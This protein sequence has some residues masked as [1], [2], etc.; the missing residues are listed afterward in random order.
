MTKT[1]EEGEFHIEH[2]SSMEASSVMG[3]EYLGGLIL[4]TILLKLGPRHAAV[5]ACVS[6]RLRAAASED[7][8]WRDFCAADFDLSCPEAPQ[9]T[10]CASFKVAYEQWLTSFL[11]YPLPLVR[12]A[13]Q[14][15]GGIR[16][17]MS[18]NFPEANDTLRRGAT[19][20]EIKR[21]E[22]KLGVKFPI[23]TRIL[24]RFCDGQDTVAFD[25][26]Q[27]RKL[28]PLGI[29]GGYEFYN[30]LINVHLLPLSQIVR[31]S[32]LM[33]R[34][35]GF[36]SKNVIVAMSNYLEKWF[37]LNCSSGQ[38]YVGTKDLLSG[39]GMVPCVPSTLVMP[40]CGAADVLPQGGLMLWLE[41]HCRR[42]YAGSIQTRMTRKSRSICLYPEAVPQ[43][44]I[45]R[46]SQTRSSDSEAPPIC[47]TAVTNGVKVHASA[48][49]VPE[50]SVVDG[51]AEYY[52]S[53]SIRMS[54]LPEECI[55][56]GIYYSSCQL[57]SRHWII[58]SKDN[59]VA[60]VSGEGVIGLHPHLKPN[61]KEFVYESCTPLPEASGSVEG[62]FTFVPG[63][64]AYPEGPAFDVEVAPFLLE[65]P[66]YIF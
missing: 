59:V 7:N 2:S 34:M 35:M 65:V 49:F 46:K 14:L 4:E 25:N 42:L 16:S 60:Q 6:S 8:L 50:L 58:K 1:G 61:Q 39:G 24:Y 53:Y 5:V 10:P 11:M 23:P 18:T 33:E 3:L 47:S 48:V 30:H 40:V 66:D 9:G 17:W 22:E 27:H 37:F 31:E 28:A 26:S 54:L 45:V 29:I 44:C 12:R 41:E 63:G 55:L 19:E 51:E 20:A 52:Y 32:K 13:K 43:T 62:S 64:L 36:S 57:S 15:W 38:L 56:N 21:V